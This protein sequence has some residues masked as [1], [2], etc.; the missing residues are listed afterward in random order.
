MLLE[1]VA[2]LEQIMLPGAYL[3]SLIEL[4][5][6]APVR[7]ACKAL[8]LINSSLPKLAQVSEHHLP[9]RRGCLAT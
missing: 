8:R 5:S 1:L 3:S 9:P 4:A 7:I 6:T 2:A